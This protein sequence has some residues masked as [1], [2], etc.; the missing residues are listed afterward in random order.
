LSATRDMVDRAC[1]KKAF[2]RAARMDV[3]VPSGLADE[4]EKLLA[5]RCVDF[6]GLARRGGKAVFGLTKTRQWLEWGSPGILLVACD[7]SAE[8]REKLRGHASGVPLV[9]ALTA[10][11][12]GSA[13]GRERIAYGGVA[14]GRLAI[15]LLR[16]ARR[17]AGFRR[18]LGG[19]PG[20]AEHRE[21]GS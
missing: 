17:L 10:A 16:D 12:L 5:R 6:I 11:E 18:S 3:A 20:A 19:P 7:G 21:S 1:A 2:P 8:E 14:R 4:V 9:T 15:N 13:V